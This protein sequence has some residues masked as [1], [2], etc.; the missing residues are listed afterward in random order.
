MPQAPL[1]L[2]PLAAR[3]A[4]I[5]PFY[6]MEIVKRADALARAGRP[7]IRLSI[8]EPDFGAPPA[9]VAA[10]ERAARR[11]EGGYTPAAGIEPLRRA[12]ARWHGQTWGIDLDWQ[13]VLVTA[14]ASG[15]LLLACAALVE[16]GTAVLMADPGYPCNRHFVAAF[17]GEARAVPVG[18]AQ[19]FQLDAASVRAHWADDVRGVLLA[20][21]GNPTGT[22][23]AHDE[24]GRIVDAVRERG[25]YAMV[26]E[27]YLGLSYG[28][29]PRSALALGEDIVSIGSF[30]K[31]FHL[32][33]WRLGW[34][35]LPPAWVGAFEKL[36]QNLYI[37]APALAQ[38]A[39]LACFEEPTQALLRERRDELRS[40]RDAI[41][42]ALRALGF[43]VPAEPDGAFYVWLDASGLG[44]DSE[45]LASE[46]LEDCAVAVV[47]GKDFCQHDPQ[48]WL[49]LSYAADRAALD[50]A[51]AR[52]RGWLGQRTA[53]R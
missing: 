30:S 7:V 22:S 47:P 31:Y 12:I 27:I 10:L 9:V 32:T 2:P 35:V 8:G 29:T 15:A 26:D 11:G 5:A 20:S 16:P 39:A 17:G 50:E 37:C 18:A 28:T 52:M 40:R 23:L 38:H 4:R 24:L 6:V 3:N 41:V 25:G 45:R 43:G 36:A 19:R 48:R 13:R 53:V 42:P 33:G 14:G 34:L 1:S 44:N 49:R 21:P 46:L 51:L